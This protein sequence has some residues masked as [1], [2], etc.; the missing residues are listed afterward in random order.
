MPIPTPM[1][2][3]RLV[4]RGRLRE[5]GTRLA[6]GRFRFEIRHRQRRSH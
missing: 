4:S 3:P 5:S 6:D 2:A 1:M